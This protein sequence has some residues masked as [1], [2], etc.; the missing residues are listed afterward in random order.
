MPFFLPLLS[1]PPPLYVNLRNQ[2][3]FLDFSRTVLF[4]TRIPVNRRKKREKKRYPRQLKFYW[5]PFSCFLLLQIFI[6]ALR[7]GEPCQQL[8]LHIIMSQPLARMVRNTSKHVSDTNY[9]ALLF[10][11]P[12]DINNTFYWAKKLSAFFSIVLLTKSSTRAHSC[13]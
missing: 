8:A 2:D 4:A 5:S 13:W 7:K 3:Y 6:F 12:P 10:K 9:K 1:S 11:A